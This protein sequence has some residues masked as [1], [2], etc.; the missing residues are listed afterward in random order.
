MYVI[1]RDMKSSRITIIVVVLLV[2]IL[3]FGVLFFAS[4]PENNPETPLPSP[5]Q[6]QQILATPTPAQQ[7]QVI[8][9]E[10]LSISDD[11]VDFKNSLVATVQ[12]EAGTSAL[13]YITE[14]TTIT[15]ADG[16]EVARTTLGQ[17]DQIQV[18]AQPSEGGYEALRIQTIEVTAAP[19]IPQV[20]TTPTAAP[21]Q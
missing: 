3:L 14:D 12:L 11:T 13:I 17:G 7:E 15:D 16:E 1:V 19:T 9:G 5:V 18:I 10:I 6:S 21:M 2:V 20:T 4:Q 8:D